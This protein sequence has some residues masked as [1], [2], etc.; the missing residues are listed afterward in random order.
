VVFAITTYAFLPQAAV[1]FFVWI[2]Y[3]APL[4]TLVTK[5]GEKNPCMRTSYEVCRFVRIHPAKMVSR[6]AFRRDAGTLDLIPRLWTAR[7]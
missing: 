3:R 6:K 7:I 4:T 5:V 1:R 2:T